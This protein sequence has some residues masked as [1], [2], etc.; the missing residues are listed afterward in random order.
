MR[1]YSTS[2]SVASDRCQTIASISDDFSVG[3][4]RSFLHWLSLSCF[5]E[6]NFQ[7]F[8]VFASALSW[9]S[10]FITLFTPSQLFISMFIP[11][12]IRLFTPSQLSVFNRLFT[13]SQLF[14]KLFTASRLFIMLFIPSQLFTAIH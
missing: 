6:K 3:L 10:L 8:L 1:K 4:I 2:V 7:D 12:F 14:I 5:R 9:I 11:L 13:S